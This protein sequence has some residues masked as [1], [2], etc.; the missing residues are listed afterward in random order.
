V[1]V[2][3]ANLVTFTI[4]DLAVAFFSF[5]FLENLTYAVFVCVTF[6]DKHS[7]CVFVDLKCKDVNRA[8]LE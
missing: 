7:V 5:Y 1:N 3:L 8:F 2:L 6:N 4:A